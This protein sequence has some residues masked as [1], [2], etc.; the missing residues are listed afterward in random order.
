MADISHRAKSF[1]KECYSLF[2][3]A[4]KRKE[5]GITKGDCEALKRNFAFFAHQN[6]LES[7]NTHKE[8]YPSILKH[9]FNNQKCCVS[10]MENE[11]FCLYQGNKDAI[12]EASDCA[13][14]RSKS[15]HAV[16]YEKLWKVLM[17]HGTN[18]KLDEI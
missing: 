13:K 12:K 4:T 11:G 5:T 3:N 16:M 17:A 10:V 14:L 1:G 2:H 15:M 18:D 9:H 6:K 8:R 7:R